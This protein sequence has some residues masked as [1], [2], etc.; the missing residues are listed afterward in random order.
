VT[1]RLD[2]GPGVESERLLAAA[3]VQGLPLKTHCRIKQQFVAFAKR[4]KGSSWS[5]WT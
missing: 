5:R 4:D 1:P 2:P 3:D